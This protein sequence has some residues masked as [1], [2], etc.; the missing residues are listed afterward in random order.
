[1]TD[2]TTGAGAEIPYRFDR[3]ATA[4]ELHERFDD[5][6]APG[7]ESDEEVSV[8]GRVM[9]VRPQGKLAFARL[10]D[11]SGSIQLFARTGVTDDLAGFASLSL[12]DWI[13]ARGR[14]LKTRKGELS[15]GVESWVLLAEARQSFGDKWKGVTDSE[16]RF[17][18]RSR[19]LGQLEREIGSPVAK[20]RRVIH[21][22]QLGE[23]RVHRSRDPD[24]ALDPRRCDRSAVHDASQRSRHRHVSAHRSGAVLEASRRG[25]VRKGLRTCKG[26][27]Q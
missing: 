8:A 4:A 14:V 26:F 18:P 13:G 11:S 23:S 24:T 3:T 6:L 1:M 17:R 22:T 2:G 5:L 15:V 25:W 12:A 27:S 16:I 9:L 19:S 10:D 20:S 21:K 7:E